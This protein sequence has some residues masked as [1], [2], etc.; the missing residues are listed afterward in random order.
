MARRII[1]DAF[2]EVHVAAP[3]A[4]C[5]ARD[6]KG[7]YRK[8]RRGEIPDFTGISAPYEA[9]DNADLVIASD[10]L[11]IDDACDDVLRVVTARARSGSAT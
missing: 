11:S 3:L 9:P 2:V 4:I 10:K 5:E 7:L 6:P 1:G 8:A